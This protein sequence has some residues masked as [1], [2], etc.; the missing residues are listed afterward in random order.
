M[1][2]K[3]DFARVPGYDPNGN[4]RWVISHPHFILDSEDV[5][6]QDRYNV[7]LFRASLLGGKKYHTKDYAGGIVFQGDPTEL[8]TRINEF[9]S[10]KEWEIT[11]VIFRKYP[12]GDIIALLPELAGDNNWSD[13]CMSY[14]H[15]GQHGVA[16]YSG[17]MKTTLPASTE[18]AEDLHKELTLLWY[19]L[20][21]MKRQTSEDV[22]LRR[23]EVEG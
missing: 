10:R 12:N 13:T 20:R 6:V 17:V 15:V 22:E 2:A 7:A 1:I 23:K 21:S 3:E 19:N 16:N 4:S 18:E 8:T 5:A 9:L 14:M 11:K